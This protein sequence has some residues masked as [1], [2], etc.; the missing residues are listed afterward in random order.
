MAINLEEIVNKQVV[1]QIEGMKDVAVRK[2]LTY[3]TVDG[4]ALKMDAYYPAGFKEGARLPSVIFVHG[5]APPGLS[6]EPKDWGQYVGW[7][8]LAAASG[9]IG[10]TFNHRSGER[11]TRL[12]NPASDV[13]D[14]IRHVRSHASELG[15]DEN[16]LCIWAASAGVPYGAR[17]A[18]RAAPDYVRAIVIY[19]GL[20]DLRA[21][22]ERIPPD[23]TDNILREFSALHHLTQNGGHISPTFIVRADLDRAALNASIDRFVDEANRL[24]A[25]VQLIYHP[26][27]HHAFDVLDGGDTSREIIQKTLAFITEHV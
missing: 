26:Q 6:K 25:N 18:M 4:V 8:Q 2:D 20:M 24:G 19:Y 15:I 16:R 22:R 9:L 12:E 13:D 7:G 23:V 3:K 1:C 17:A 21:V 14:L 10:V 27:G 11:L 5:D